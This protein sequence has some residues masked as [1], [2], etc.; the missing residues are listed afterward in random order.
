MSTA[1]TETCATGE[2]E[3]QLSKVCIDRQR[4]LLR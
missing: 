2:R 4:L 1:S 3:L